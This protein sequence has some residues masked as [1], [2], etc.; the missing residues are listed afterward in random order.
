MLKAC[1]AFS[2]ILKQS[3][4]VDEDQSG[5]VDLND[6]L[7]IYQKY[8]ADNAKATSDRDTKEAFVALGGNVSF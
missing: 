3:G 6:F 1:R 8:R 2:N 4:Q 7:K 5:E